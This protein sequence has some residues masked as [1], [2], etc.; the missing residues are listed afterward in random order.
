MID[1]DDIPDPFAPAPSKPAKPPRPAAPVPIAALPAQPVYQ[2]VTLILPY[3][4]S[5]NVYWRTFMPKGFKAPV[6]T[7]S[8]EAKEYKA[9]CERIAILAGITS[10]IP[11]RVI[12][13]VLLF[14]HRPQDWEK[15]IRTLGNEW[16]N[17]VQAIDLDNANKVIMDALKNVV[18]EDDSLVWE[19][20]GYR[21]TPDEH[22]KRAQVTI[23]KYIT[24]GIENE[25]TQH[26]LL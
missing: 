15:R 24:E 17:G 20:H 22:G 3:P 6:T 14:P 7:L 18:F 16:D 21:M 23:S 2:P 11:G 26:S 12:V 9:E 10:T 13:D 1:Y 19:L 8:K 4:V 25:Q 5:A